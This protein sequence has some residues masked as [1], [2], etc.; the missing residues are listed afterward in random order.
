MLLLL[1]FVN[2]GFS[3]FILLNSRMFLLSFLILILT[4]PPFHLPAYLNNR[5]G[6]NVLPRLGAG[7]IL[8]C[9]A[10]DERQD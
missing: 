5:V 1:C 10:A 3:V 7:P 9:V 6:S 8:P 2:L 4:P